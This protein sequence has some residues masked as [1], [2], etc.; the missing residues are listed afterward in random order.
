MRSSHTLPDSET[1]CG[2]LADLRRGAPGEPLR[3]TV[4]VPG[5][6]RVDTDL[7]YSQMAEPMRSYGDMKAY[8]S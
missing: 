8:P 6:H 3:Q 1:T 5:K 7:H 4:L 2:L